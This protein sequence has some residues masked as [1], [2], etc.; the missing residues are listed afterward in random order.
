MLRGENLPSFH[1][2]SHYSNSGIIAHFLIRIEP[3]TKYAVKLQG[4]CFDV[5]DR[6][7]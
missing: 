1:Y 2:G 7:F 6:L 4:G 3:F 5:A